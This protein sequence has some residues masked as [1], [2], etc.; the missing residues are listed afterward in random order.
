MTWDPKIYRQGNYFQNEISESF[1][2]NFDSQLFGNILDI[3]C[4]DGYYSNLVANS[5]K[6]GQVLGID[7][8]ADMIHYANEHWANKNLTFQRHNIE[9]FQQDSTFDFILSFWCLHWTNVKLSLPNIFNALKNGGIF[10][11]VF[12]SFS[13]NSILQTWA[14][15]AKQENYI[16]LKNRC[17]NTDEKSKSNFYLLINILNQL[18]FKRVNLNLKTTRTYLPDIN[19]FKN[20][21]VAMPFIKTFP[22]ERLEVLIN[23]MLEAFQVICQRK[24]AGKLYYETRPIF[25]EAV[26]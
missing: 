2:K 13:D 14:E 22:S 17:K 11:T 19:Y 10:Y 5:V 24:Y 12:S 7:S 3:G 8:S 25:L 6:Q 18:P 9:E 16:D 20:L 21:L 4:G 23:D 26:K 1:R 15:L